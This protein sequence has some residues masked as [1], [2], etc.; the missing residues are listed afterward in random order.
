MSSGAGFWFMY[1]YTAAIGHAVPAL[2]FPFPQISLC[3]QPLKE[4]SNAG[5]SGSLFY[6]SPD[7]NFIM[8]TVQSKEASFLRKLLPGYFLV[9]MGMGWRHGIVLSCDTR[10]SF[11]SS[12]FFTLCCAV[13]SHEMV[14]RPIL[15]PCG[16]ACGLAGQELCGSNDRSANSCRVRYC[17]W[18][19]TP[20]ASGAEAAGRSRFFSR[21]AWSLQNLT[22]NTKTL[23]PKF[24]GLYCYQS[25]L[26]RHIRLVIMNNVLPTHVSYH[27]K[28]DLKVYKSVFVCMGC[29]IQARQWWL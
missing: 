24:F 26:G 13:S 12:L 19:G 10:R 8:K 7:D 5:A 18:F 25:L 11:F 3:N 17:V 14:D 23:L 1:M 6:I 2:S 28:Y 21:M 15:Y 16:T 29:D 22:Q 20:S 4:V 27:E 9:C